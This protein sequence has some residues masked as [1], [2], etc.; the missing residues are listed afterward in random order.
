VTR[1]LGR[2][3]ASILLATAALTTLGAVSTPAVAQTFHR[4]HVIVVRLTSLG[5]DHG[6]TGCPGG[7]DIYAIKSLSNVVGGGTIC[8]QTTDAR[9]CIGLG[10][11]QTTPA[12][13]TLS[14]ARGSLTMRVSLASEVVG[15]A[16]TAERGV[17]HIVSGTGR[18]AGVH[19]RIGGGGTITTTHDGAV[20]QLIYV[21]WF[22]NS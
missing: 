3:S 6:R 5:F 4:R 8:R 13:F 15:N 21:V 14:T 19:G 16:T 17:G 1:T 12:V 10:C 7:V 20:A 2:R 9:L 18:Y 11:R 22:T